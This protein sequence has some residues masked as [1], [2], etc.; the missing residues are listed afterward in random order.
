[1]SL[2]IFQ[3]NIEDAV[4]YAGRV[5]APELPS[6]FSDNFHDAWNKGYLTA[7]SISGLTR[8]SRALGEFVDDAI[9]KTGDNSFMATE[10]DGY[11]DL[12]GFNA[13]L[14]AHK[15]KN[16]TLELDPITEEMIQQRADE[17]GKRQL[18]LSADFDRRER[19]F[20]GSV[21]S[22]LGTTAAA[23]ADPVNLVA[24][25]LAA[26]ASYGVV[27]TALAWG[28]IAGGSQAAIEALNASSMERIQPGYRDSG[29]GAMNIAEA[30]LFGSVLGGGVKGIGALWSRNRSAAWPRT[31]RDAGNVVESEAQIAATNPLPGV[32]GEAVHRTALNKAIDDLANGRPV[33]VDGIVAPETFAARNAALDP[34]IGARDEVMN[35]QAAARAAADEAAAT[36]GPQAELPFAQTEAQ[37][38]AEATGA[39]LTQGV[40]DVARLAGYDMPADEAARIADRVA[41]LDDPEKARALLE[42]VFVRPSTVADT[43]P[44]VE[45]PSNRPEKINTANAR[46]LRDELQPAKIEEMR[47]DPDLP[48]TVSRDLDKLMLEQPDLEVP[49]GVTVDAEGAV[50]PATRK[51]E[52]VVAEADARLAAAEEIK[53]C[54]GPYPAEAAE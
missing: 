22:F 18:A 44:V 8:R 16:P 19:T 21:G 50:V 34:V 3:S 31:V 29:E 51:V 49:M 30:A 47:V 20:G 38:L 32:E 1:M 26:P 24:F 28:G 45:K 43:L 42:E 36:A 13:K 53:A 6:T 17:I 5:S 39:K 23:I 37:A 7:Q 33:D 10:Q 15:A 11:A 52:S 25:P 54:V 12:D 4:N 2:D 41:K 14:A 35:A 27:G 46:A 48:D 9:R 40:Q